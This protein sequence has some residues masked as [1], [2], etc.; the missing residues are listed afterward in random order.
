M[1][2]TLAFLLALALLAIPAGAE[3]FWIFAAPEEMPQSEEYADFEEYASFEAVEPRTLYVVN[4]EEY[5]TLRSAPDADAN[6]LLRVPLG[7][8]VV[9][10]GCDIGS[11]SGV[12]YDGAAGYVLSKYLSD[13]PQ[14]TSAGASLDKDRGYARLSTDEIEVYASSEQVDQYGYYAAANA[15]DANVSTTWAEAAGGI[16]KGEWL[17]F[18]FEEREIIGFAIHA[19]YQKSSDVYKKN[20]R[21]KKILVSV[22]GED[23][24]AVTLKDTRSEQIVLFDRPQAS[25]YLSIEIRSA[26]AGSHY[27]DTCITDVRILLAD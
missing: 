6:G 7:A 26:Y 13:A 23:G 9:Y 21:P 27:A 16:G 24:M 20:A 19:G 1:R 15:N 22:A 3:E 25:D 10:Y 8:E 2:R 12:E 18:F 5:V 17:S 4:C 11:Y 14:A